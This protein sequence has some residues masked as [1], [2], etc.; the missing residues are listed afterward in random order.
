MKK[1]VEMELIALGSVPITTLSPTVS[2]IHTEREREEEHKIDKLCFLS[3]S[4][5]NKTISL[6]WLLFY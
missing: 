5:E 1:L 6:G 4:L 2:N 3:F